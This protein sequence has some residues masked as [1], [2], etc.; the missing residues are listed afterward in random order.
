MGLW[1]K[2]A[3]VAFVVGSTSFLAPIDGRCDEAQGGDTVIEVDPE[4]EPRA[5]SKKPDRPEY[6]IWHSDG[7]WHVRT[8]T[9]GKRRVFRGQIKIIDGTVSKISNYEGLEDARRGKAKGKKA[10]PADLGR[11]N[12]ARNRIDFQFET[13]E[14][15]DG[16]DFKVNDK[17]TRLQFDLKVDGY[18]HREMILIGTAG[19]HPP[20]AHFSIANPDFKPTERGT[21]PPPK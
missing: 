11:L 13:H 7:M 6:F 15:G 5:W 9:G 8:R 12:D 14:Y 19:K 18:E 21:S 4:G 16:F 20:G 1:Q 10:K 17:A 3:L 2:C